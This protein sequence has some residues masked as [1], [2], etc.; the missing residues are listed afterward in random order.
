MIAA[1]EADGSK[2]WI[3]ADITIDGTLVSGIGVRPKGNSTLCS[4]SGDG[5]GTNN[6]GGKGGV[7]AFSSGISS[8]VP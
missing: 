2:E 7:G 8:D 6:P 3:Q 4:L 5:N 1:Y